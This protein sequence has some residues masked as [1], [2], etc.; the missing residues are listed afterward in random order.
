MSDRLDLQAILLSILPSKNVYFQPPASMSLKYPCII[1]RRNDVDAK[2]ADDI[3]YISR[4][5]YML[6][7]IDQNPD[8]VIV[9]KLLAL[10]L[11]RFDRNFVKDGLNHDT[12]I[13]YY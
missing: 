11:C 8:G 4:V 2:K 5:S 7:Y 6:T 13:L 1:Y 10:P 9:D 3:T 12:F